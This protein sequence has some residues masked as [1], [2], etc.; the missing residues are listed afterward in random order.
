M[1]NITYFYGA[2]ILVLIFAIETFF[3]NIKNFVNEL[4]YLKKISSKLRIYEIVF[5]RILIAFLLNSIVNLV[6]VFFLLTVSNKFTVLMLE[7]NRTAIIIIFIVFNVLG[8]W[9]IN[10]LYERTPFG[11]N[12]TKFLDYLIGTELAQYSSK[13]L[14]QSLRIIFLFF[15]ITLLLMHEFLLIS[16]KVV[17]LRLKLL[18]LSSFEINAKNHL[19]EKEISTKNDGSSNP[20][21]FDYFD[22]AQ[23]SPNSKEE[24]EKVVVL[25]DTIVLILTAIGLLLTSSLFSSAISISNQYLFIMLFVSVIITK[26]TANH[27]RVVARSDSEISKDSNEKKSA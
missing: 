6:L 20:L 19:S 2:T 5:R 24:L 22:S 14:L 1:V 7:E 23:H 12:L 16:I 26:I 15:K 13:F 11:K 10:I 21:T 17:L 27:E 25:L 4:S 8:L 9:G 18:N 3:V